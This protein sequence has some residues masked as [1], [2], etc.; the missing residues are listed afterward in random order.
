MKLIKL[1]KDGLNAYFEVEVLNPPKLEDWKEAIGVPRN[2][3]LFRFVNR[4]V[5]FLGVSY[6]I[7]A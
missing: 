7:S 5:N 2:P 3:R 4:I 1:N 6:R